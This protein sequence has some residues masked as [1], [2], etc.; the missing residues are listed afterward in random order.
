[1]TNETTKKGWVKKGAI[2]AGVL[3][4][5]FIGIGMLG[6]GDST[7][8]NDNSSNDTSDATNTSNESESESESKNDEQKVYAVGDTIEESGKIL[9]VNEVTRDYQ[10]TDGFTVPAAN[11]EF[12]LIDLSLENNSNN[13]I[14]YFSDDFKLLD[15]R[16][17]KNAPSIQGYSVDSEGFLEIAPDGKKDGLIVY[18]VG[19][20]ET[21]LTLIYSA[22]F[23]TGKE[24]QVKI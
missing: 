16:G 24:I 2:V 23:W 5:A 14:T 10:F 4:V 11:K 6:G 15:S 17:V 19:A 9:T 8:T 18:E 22:T 3:L 20:D 1:M 7:T 13:D 12:V 21:D